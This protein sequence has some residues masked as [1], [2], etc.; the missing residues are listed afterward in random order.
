MTMTVWSP[1]G[2]DPCCNGTLTVDS[3]SL[4]TPGWM[5]QNLS[6]LWFSAANYRG[7][8]RQIPRYPGQIGYPKRLDPFEFSL[9]FWVTGMFDGSG[10]P[11][12]TNWE[13]LEQNLEDLWDAVFSPVTTGDG[14]RACTLTMPSGTPR[15]ARV[16]F[17]PLR[18][19]SEIDDAELVEFIM[20]GT[21]L[22]GRFQP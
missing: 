4:N 13:G 3:F 5:V 9:V 6:S 15:T 20:S 22:G 10:T 1:F 14:A 8:N 7:T 2:C 12:S 19:T 18:K 17:E 21:I 16:Q 11:W